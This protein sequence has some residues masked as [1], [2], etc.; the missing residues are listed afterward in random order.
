MT[1]HYLFNNHVA[2][3]TNGTDVLEVKADEKPDLFQQVVNM[4]MQGDSEDAF[5]LIVDSSATRFIAKKLSTITDGML[6]LDPLTNEVV[7]TTVDGRRLPIVQ[8]FAARIRDAWSRKDAQAL[9]VYKAFMI[10]ASNNPNDVSASDLFE[11]ITVNKLPLSEDGDVLAYKIVRPDFMDIHSN[12]KD[13]TPGNVVTEDN[14]DYNRD[15]TCSNGL[16]FCSKDY[17]PAYGG[18]FGSG[19]KEN[20]LVLLKI[21][22]ADVAAFPRDYNNAKGRCRKY[23]VVSELPTAFFT[24]IVSLMEQVPFVDLKQLGVGDAIASR[25]GMQVTTYQEAAKDAVVGKTAV[26]N[27]SIVVTPECRWYVAIEAENQPLK[28]IEKCESRSGARQMRD[29]IVSDIDNRN[30]NGTYMGLTDPKVSVY[31]SWA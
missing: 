16:H 7:F 20:K 10:K 29:K 4:C 17:L 24:A 21:D 18:G 5:D 15:V 8:T 3:L 11:F 31:D 1:I 19:N 25:L 23:T 9:S 6:Q 2:V 13:H 28:L 12:T 22:P 14:V 26:V 27:D 30:V